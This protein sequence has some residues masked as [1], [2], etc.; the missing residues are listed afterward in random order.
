MLDDLIKFSQFAA[1]SLAILGV[2]TLVSRHVARWTGSRRPQQ[3]DASSG[4]IRPSTAKSIAII[5]IGGLIF[6]FGILVIVLKSSLS[7]LLFVVFGVVCFAVAW[8]SLTH[9]HDVMWDREG[10]EGPSQELAT[11]LGWRRRRLLWSE[12]TSAD[13]TGNDNHYVEALDDRR[14]YWTTSHK[15]HD[16]FLEALRR[17]RPDLFD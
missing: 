9:A 8:L 2:G 17:N 3:L 12:L 16:Y 11:A 5:G 14:V 15:G 13:I 4:I 6:A 7:G 1:V 10:V